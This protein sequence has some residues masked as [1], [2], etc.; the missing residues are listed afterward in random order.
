MSMRGAVDL[1]RIRRAAVGYAEVVRE[2]PLLSSRTLGE[3]VGGTIA[4]KAEN[5][6][7]T[8]SFKLRGALAKI[9]ALDPAHAAAGVVAGSAGNHGQAVAYAA[10]AR[11]LACEV[12][13]PLSAPNQKLDA[14]AE[15]GAT[16]QLVGDSVD[17]A[18][19]A[20]RERAAASGMAFI[21]PFDDPDVVAGQGG[22]GL[23]L[24]AQAPDLALAIVPV[25]GGGLVSGTAIALKALRP[26]VRV[27]GVQVD[28]CA[29]VPASLA[30]GAPVETT[31]AAPTIADGIAVKRPGELTV[32][33]MRAWVDEVV[34][35]PE[36]AVAEAMVLLL[37]RAK[38]VVEGAGAVGVAALLSGA[39]APAQRGT[40]AVVLSGGNVDAGL[41]A[42]VARRHESQAGR[43]LVLLTRVPDRP[44]ALATLLELVGRQNANLVDITHVREG[45]DLHVRETAVQLVL[46]TRG[47]GHASEVLRAIADAGYATSTLA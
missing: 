1:E 9:A 18:L 10:R 43:R 20:A 30:G 12:F 6:Q 46:E 35:V 25:G 36:D 45:L 8:G 42:S 14:C 26:G 40:T 11:G 39:V 37:E 22:V 4:L 7:R 17:A 2:T 29:P 23:E 5:L 3:R 38:L 33:L 31:R 44:G 34:V 13:M 47:P 41:L 19:A 15:F 27:V 21:H 28:R 32:A 24:A 16:V